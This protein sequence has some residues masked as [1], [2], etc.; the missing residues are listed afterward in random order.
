ML[1]FNFVL[2]A[3][4]LPG[5]LLRLLESVIVTIPLCKNTFLKKQNIFLKIKP[6]ICDKTN[7]ATGFRS[8]D[9]YS[10]ILRTLSRE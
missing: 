6:L 3:Y 10:A 1:F 5:I 4:S 7:A 2:Y 8:S 9:L